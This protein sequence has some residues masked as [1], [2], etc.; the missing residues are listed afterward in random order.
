MIDSTFGWGTVTAL[1]PLRV[2][3]DGDSIAV[4][5]TP[6]SLIDPANLAVADRVRCELAGTR[7]IVHGRAAG[8]SLFDRA[9]RNRLVNGNF[10]T[11]QRGVVTAAA[12]QGYC[13]DRW[14]GM[15]RINRAR[16]TV[17]LVD[18]SG[19]SGSNSTVSRITGQTIPGLSGV[20]TAIRGTQIAATTGG[21]YYPDA[22]FSAADVVAGRTYTVSMYVRASVAKSVRLSVQWMNSAGVNVGN[23]DGSIVALAANTWTR[24]SMTVAAISGASIGQP[25][26]YSTAAWAVGNTLDATGLLF[27][28]SATLNA[29]IDPIILTF[30]A[31]P[32]G[33][34][35]TIPAGQSIGQ[36]VERANVE[37][38]LYALTWTG[39]ATARVYNVGAT[40]PA[41]ASSPVL[42]TLDGLADVTAELTGGTASKVQLESLASGGAP[43]A[44]EVIPVSDE[45]AQCQRYY[46]RLSHPLGSPTAV[47]LPTSLMWFTSTIAYGP[48]PYPVEMRAIPTMLVGGATAVAAFVSGSALSSTSVTFQE[49]S[50]STARMAVGTAAV[51]VNLAGWAELNPG[52]WIAADAEL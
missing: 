2:K 45:L 50:K 31:A 46:W 41:F 40:A 36:I 28:E 43:T 49:S 38:G 5:A 37:A 19:W 14:K 13:F 4:P 44:F 24:L 29:Y 8:I 11:N 35:V 12:V 6:D 1:G 21:L 17:G 34:P 16:N 20:T 25:Y 27:E 22:A 30:T 47:M 42:V 10:R 51:T 39:T 52:Y 33:Q 7:L 26:A 9:R 18:A 48:V 3:L 32:Q 23:S 15:G